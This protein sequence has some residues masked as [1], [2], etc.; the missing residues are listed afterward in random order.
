MKTKVKVMAEVEVLDLC[1]CEQKHLL[2]KP[3]TLYRFIVDLDCKECVKLA[4]EAKR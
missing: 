1:L 4:M 2:L 3:Y